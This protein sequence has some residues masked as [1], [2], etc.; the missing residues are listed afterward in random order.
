MKYVFFTYDGAILSVANK[1]IQEG[2]EVYVCQIRNPSVLGIK[3]WVNDVENPETKKRR[4]SLHN[5]YF[6]KYRLDEMLEF[7]GQ[8]KNKDNFFVVFDYNNM[9]KI[10]EKVLRMGY[11]KGLLPLTYD[12]E[13]EK[14]RQLAKKFVSNYYP[15]LKLAEVKE[16]SKV[17]DV[18]SFIQ[19]SD[20]LWVI[21]SDGNFA[22]TL[23]PDKDDLEMSKAQI[24]SELLENKKDFE[25]SKIIAEEKI[26]N[27]IEFT[28]QLV[29]WDGKPI[30]SQIEIETRMLG[31]LDIGPQT[32]GNE[33]LIVHT[34]LN[35]KINKIIFPPIIYEEARNHKGLYIRDA[36]ILSDGEDLYFTEFAGNRWGWGGIFSELSASMTSGGNISNYFEK[37]AIGEDPYVY[38]YGTSLAL[39]TLDVDPKHAGLPAGDSRLTIQEGYE[40]NF[41]MYQIRQND[42]KDGIISIGYRTF[43][44]APLGYVTGRGDTIESAVDNL[45]DH[46][47][48]FSLKGVYYRPESDYLSL[49]N[50]KCILKRL[51]FLKEK[52]LIS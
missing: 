16:F 51:A 2:N 32:G 20:K 15:D 21:K 33:N 3:S 27:C 7:L 5:G 14:D 18:I 25:K 39:Y 47:D 19:E 50:N 44:S 4:L 12:Y 48:K 41:F 34:E 38:K 9:C 13:M 52:G 1:L 45:Y 40:H 17:Q 46:V 6:K 23:V 8:Q 31:P 35:D 11:S 26:I 36:G 49:E 42:K 29:F 30:Y 24:T 43:G 28:P 22:E 10:A 37:L